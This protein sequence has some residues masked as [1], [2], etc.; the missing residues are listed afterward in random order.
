[1]ERLW[2]GWRSTYVND[3]AYAEM[4]DGGCVFCGLLAHGDDREAQVVRRFERCAVVLNAY[5]YGSGHIMVIPLRHVGQL[6]DL[7]SAELTELWSVVTD[8]VRAI[9]SAYDPGG[10]NVGA[11][12]GPAA[13]AG[14]PGH[15]HVHALPR[16]RG[17]TNFMTSVAE[18]RVLPEP[19]SVSYDKIANAWPAA[20]G[21]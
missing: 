7:D 9:K 17:D 15:L 8:G 2:A 16:W 14:V 4:D 20:T 11:N 1:L 5:P 13:G 3:V 19:L 18:A 12:L 6:E 10:V 21:P